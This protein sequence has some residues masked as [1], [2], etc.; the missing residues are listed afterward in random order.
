MS[1]FLFVRWIWI[2][3]RILDL[4]LLGLNNWTR[5][6]FVIWK[7]LIRIVSHFLQISFSTSQDNIAFSLPRLWHWLIF[8][9]RFL[10]KCSWASN[11]ILCLKSIF[12]LLFFH[13]LHHSYLS[14]LYLLII[15]SVSLC[16]SIFHLWF[17]LFCLLF[18]FS[19]WLDL[20]NILLP[21]LFSG[22]SLSLLRASRWTFICLFLLSKSFFIF[23]SIFFFLSLFL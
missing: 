11:M 20:E 1:L 6:I 9:I 5:A 2:E 18:F 12:S 8:Y 19:N 23:N 15:T 16:T 17:F 4:L 14:H 7:I 10:Y 21:S 22:R 13:L 3:A